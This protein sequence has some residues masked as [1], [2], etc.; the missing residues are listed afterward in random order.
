MEGDSKMRTPTFS[1]KPED[2]HLWWMRFTAFAT[3]MKFAKALNGPEAKLPGKESDPI[4]TSTTDGR[5][6]EATNYKVAYVEL[7]QMLARVSMKKDD[8]PMKLFEQ[9]SAVQNRAR[10]A[11]TTLSE[12]DVIGAVISSAPKMYQG[13]IAAEAMRKGTT[14]TTSDL[15]KMS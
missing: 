4:D 15:W 5:A 10:I 1:G 6:E 7:R 12:D 2:F 13:V 8:S 14:L 3:V 11:G 9:N